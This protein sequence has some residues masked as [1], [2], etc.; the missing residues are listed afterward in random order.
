MK[1]HILMCLIH[2]LFKSYVSFV[3]GTGWD[4]R[5]LFTEN[6]QISA[7]SFN[8]MK[9][10][11][12]WSCQSP[13]W[14]K[15][16]IKVQCYSMYSVITWLFCVSNNHNWTHYSQNII[17]HIYSFIKVRMSYGYWNKWM[18]IKWNEILW[19]TSHCLYYMKLFMRLDL[20]GFVTGLCILD[21]I[22]QHGPYFQ[23]HFLL[24]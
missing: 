17:L 12:D 23:L 1:V 3:W 8:I 7:C 24:L 14:L 22:L 21:A 5:L 15:R 2:C 10:N 6:H 9:V 20:S 11:G 18:S 19:L 4:L 16:L 13:K